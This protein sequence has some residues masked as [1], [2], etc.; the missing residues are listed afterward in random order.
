MLVPSV[1]LTWTI[2]EDI[3]VQLLSSLFFKNFAKKLE[4]NVTLLW[5]Y[6]PRPTIIPKKG[7][8]IVFLGSSTKFI[9]NS[10]LSVAGF[11][12]H[13]LSLVCSWIGLTLCA[14]E[15]M[16][17]IEIMMLRFRRWKD[18]KMSSSFRL[19][20]SKL[21]GVHFKKGKVFWIAKSTA[22]KQL[23]LQETT[24]KVTKIERWCRLA[25]FNRHCERAVP[26]FRR[27]RN[28]AWFANDL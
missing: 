20:G 16:T 28:G 7:R 25:Y 2:N 26:T 1:K 19:R 24:R 15:L 11:C 21:S 10:L 22:S 14:Y 27:S 13:L 23:K 4:K 6:E 12:W 3:Y 9:D 8:F 5:I 17:G 18:Q